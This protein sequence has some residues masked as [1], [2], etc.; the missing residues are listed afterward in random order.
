MCLTRAW[1]PA[2]YER[3][4][5]DGGT[6]RIFELLRNPS[7]EIAQSA[8]ESPGHKESN[9]DFIIGDFDSLSPSVRA[10]YEALGVP[11]VDLHDDQDSTDLDKCLVHVR[12]RQQG[13]RKRF[14]KER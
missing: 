3:V 1:L 10:H 14:P 2:A 5:A 4:C 8:V 7:P 9:P 11:C 13:R 6:N 12:R